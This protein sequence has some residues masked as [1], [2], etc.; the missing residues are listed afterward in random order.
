MPDVRLEEFSVITEYVLKSIM[1]AAR[2]QDVADFC[3]AINA[4]MREFG[5]T[6]PV[7]QAAF[8]GQIA[9]ESDQFWHS[10]DHYGTKR[11][12]E[13]ASGS[14][15]EGRKDLGNI[16]PG[17]G[18][19]FKGHGLLQ[20]TG[21]ANHEKVH[22]ALGIDCVNHPELLC[23]PEGAARAAG[24]YWKHHGCNELAD[25]GKFEA[26]THIINGGINGLERRNQFWAV[27]K[28]TLA[29]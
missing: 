5:I 26:I 28:T 24:Y 7:R 21:A 29:I 3:P 20:T 27:A 10:R 18:V 4:A 13:Y 2:A 25:A 14:G 22:Q 12:E 15:Y 16:H 11:G 9:V 23:E 8:L 19:K 6:T 1:P 17:D